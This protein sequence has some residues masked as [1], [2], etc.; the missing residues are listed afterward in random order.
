MST[1]S[2]QGQPRNKVSDAPRA[3]WVDRYAPERTKPYLRLA[4]ADRPIGTWL[5]LLPCWWGMALS[6]GYETCN[7]ATETCGSAAE[8]HHIAPGMILFYG[9][10]FAIGAFVMRGAGCTYNDIVDRDFDAQVERTRSRPIPSGQV[11]HKMALLFLT[12][13]SLVGLA[14]LVSFNPFTVLLGLSSLGLVAIYPFMKRVTHWPQIWLGLTFNWGILMGWSA[15]AGSLSLAPLLFYAG[16]IFWTIGYD[17]IYAHQDKEDDLMVG[18]KSSAI[19]LGQNSKF[20]IG[21]FYGATIGFF[22]A[23]GFASGLGPLFFA[24]MIGAAM[25][26]LRQIRKV[27]IDDPDIC[28]KV[29]K[30][31]RD[32]GFVILA[33][34][35]L[36]HAL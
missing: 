9:L 21:V 25:H 4:R 17:T 1:S 10:L 35:I 12:F 22:V 13:L 19:R 14:V 36:G 8:I 5:L 2:P 18:V 20:W 31:N 32:F 33:A 30:S 7:I 3:N 34:I 11:S 26:L 27:D 16:A 6:Y 23:A 15:L 29:F 24:A 28:L